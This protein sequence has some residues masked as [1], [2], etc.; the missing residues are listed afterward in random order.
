M[1][2]Q[3]TPRF[4]DEQMDWVIRSL[5]EGMSQ[6]EVGQNFRGVFPDFAPDVDDEKLAEVVR[7][8]ANKY[9]TAD[10]MPYKERIQAAKKAQFGSLSP[11]AQKDT[12]LAYLQILWDRFVVDPNGKISDGV[13]IIKAADR[14][15]QKG[16]AINEP[17]K[18]P[19]G[20]QSDTYENDEEDE[21]A[22]YT[23]SGLAQSD[24]NGDHL[25]DY[26]QS[27]LMAP[28]VMNA[29]QSDE[30]EKEKAKQ[31]EEEEVIPAT[32]AMKR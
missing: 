26:S 6:T 27:G 23:N 20:F 11:I 17:P 25:D 12:R 32:L 19:P 21:L 15:S 18:Y 5:C 29:D 14:I 28:P 8:R 13:Q 24:D 16:G 4:D 31:V 30:K 2:R 3:V 1:A 10:D 9:A 7:N 22:D